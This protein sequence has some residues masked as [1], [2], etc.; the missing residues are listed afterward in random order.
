M[1]KP[2]VFEFY[3]LPEWRGR[4]FDLFDA[5]VAASGPR[6][7]E[8]QTSDSLLTTMLLTYGHDF[9]GES[10]VFRD[11]LKPSLPSRG[12]TL[13]RVTSEKESQRC[14]DAR[15]GHSEWQIELEA[16]IVGSGG[17]TFHYNLHIAT[18]TWRLSRGLAVRVSGPSSSKS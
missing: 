5:F 16:A 15:A 18:F 1:D 17:L 11:E 14:F 3:L 13:R 7:F 2:T 10:I 8:V 6:F 4:A 12:A 9:V